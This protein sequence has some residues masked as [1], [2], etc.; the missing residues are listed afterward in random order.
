[1]KGL[2]ASGRHVVLVLDEL[3]NV[4]T[5]RRQDDWTIIGILREYSQ[6]G[7]IRLIMSGFQEFF[8]KQRTEFEGP[9]VNFATPL[10]LGGFSNAEIEEFIP[11]PLDIWGQIS[12]RSE[13]LDTMITRSGI[14]AQR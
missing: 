8:L 13:M 2:Q 10:R 9:F 1:M 5:K 7:S 4:I 3:G 14:I 12:R 6:S 11:R